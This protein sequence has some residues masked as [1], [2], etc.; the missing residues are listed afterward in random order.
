MPR[1]I[2]NTE[3]LRAYDA[4]TEFSEFVIDVID[5]FPLSERFAFPCIMF[6]SSMILIDIDEDKSDTFY[7]KYATAVSLITS[8]IPFECGSTAEKYPY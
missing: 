5:E 3:A 4:Q 6:V 2:E 7:D 8:E 1:L